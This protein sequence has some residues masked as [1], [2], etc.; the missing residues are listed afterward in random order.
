M[1]PGG[2]W[3]QLPT[4]GCSRWASSCYGAGWLAVGPAVDTQVQQLAQQGSLGCEM[5]STA[6]GQR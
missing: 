4:S 3:A 6:G 1:V 5:C 2:W